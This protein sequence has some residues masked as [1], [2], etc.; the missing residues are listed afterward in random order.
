MSPGGSVV[1]RVRA[2]ACGLILALVLASCG[3]GR[4]PAT[5]PGPLHVQTTASAAQGR[6]LVQHISYT[7]DNGSRVPALFS[8]PRAYPPR[9]CLIWQN[10]LGSTKESAEILGEAAARLGLAVFSID[11]RDQGQRAQSPAQLAQ[12]LR[13][14]ARLHALVAGSINDLERAVD[15]LR[16]QPLCRHS[17]GYGG[18]GVSGMIGS[19]LAAQDRDIRA[20]IL[21]SVAP[22]WQAMI[23]TAPNNALRAIGS[24]P[25]TLRATLALL[26]PLDPDRWLR[27]ISPRPLL[28]LFYNSGPLPLRVAR[29]TVAAAGEPKTV[30]YANG[31]S[32]L[33]LGTVTAGDANPIELFLLKYL[34]EPTYGLAPSSLRQP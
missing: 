23:A 22:N 33:L 25:A 26:S 15:Y 9:G 1:I 27:Q 4:G 34:V 16:T 2:S 11:L 24:Q 20:V 12:A 8:I 17:I 19:V 29:Q 7:A 30:V 28:L 10:G 13:S 31:A 32:D 18:V 6:I 21:V 3:S 14:P 5:G